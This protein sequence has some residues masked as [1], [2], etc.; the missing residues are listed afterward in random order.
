MGV[1]LPNVTRT[2]RGSRLSCRRNRR[3]CR[4]YRMT[5]PSRGPVY[6]KATRRLLCPLEAELGVRGR[7]A[8][9]ARKLKNAVVLT[10]GGDR[11]GSYPVGG[12]C[13]TYQ[14]EDY[15]PPASAARRSPG[16]P[17][18]EGRHSRWRRATRAS[19]YAPGARLEGAGSARRLSAPC[20]AGGPESWTARG[21][22]G[23]WEVRWRWGSGGVGVGKPEASGRRSRRPRRGSGQ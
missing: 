19:G 20:T 21:R 12:P 7:A 22:A 13:V 11:H 15:L 3:I 8:R 2:Q 5:C 23:G 18:G 6:P 9:L 16:Q 4:V 10:Y 17:R 1:L 14:V